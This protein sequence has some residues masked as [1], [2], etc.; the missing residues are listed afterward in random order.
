MVAVRWCSDIDKALQGR[1][2][3]DVE[4]VWAVALNTRLEVT[5]LDMIF[6]GHISAALF[7]PREILKFA[8]DHRAGA[9]IIAHSHPSG[10]DDPSREDLV[11]TE[12][13]FHL[14]GLLEVPLL[15]HLIITETSYRSLANDG[16]FEKW[17]R[18]RP[19]RNWGLGDT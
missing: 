9:L 14:C 1:I 2:R 7:H 15:D 13:L 3:L 5:C 4:E 11:R 17:R 16:W 6:R 10:H 19:F 8:I 12:R 18:K